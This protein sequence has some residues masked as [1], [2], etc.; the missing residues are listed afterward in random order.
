MTIFPIGALVATLHGPAGISPAIAGALY[1]GLAAWMEWSG[2]R[3]DMLGRVTGP[4][5]SR[6]AG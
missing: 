3:L 6:R 1:F 5:S 4:R 2:W